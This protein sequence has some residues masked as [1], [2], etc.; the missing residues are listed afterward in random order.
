MYHEALIPQI[1][2]RPY[3]WA[4][5]VW[6]MF[7]FAA[8]SRD[9]GGEAGMNHKGLVTFDRK[10]KKDSFYAYKAWLSED[11][12]VHICSRNYVDRIE[13][14]TMINVYSNQPEVELFVN[15]ES[16]GKQQG[17]WFFKFY[18]PNAGE[19]TI[20]VKAGKDGE[21]TDEI[22]IRKVAEA[23]MDYVMQIEGA[24]VLNWFDIDEPEGFYSINDTLGN[25][26]NVPQVAGMIGKIMANANGGGEKK[27]ELAAKMDPKA[28]ENILN[29]FTLKRMLLMAKG[30]TKDQI[31]GINKMLNQI[32]KK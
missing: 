28:I 14:K 32:P 1:D 17:K 22:F 10:Y 21:L 5:H 2:A 30:M 27:N 20:S 15:G 26:R 6:N 25:L 24:V 29:G 11:P 7:D 8:D 13:E 12:F 16:V 23:N 4:T 3:L 9:E 31:I 19:Q 18:I